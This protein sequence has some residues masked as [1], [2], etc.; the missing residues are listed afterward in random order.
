MEFLD[1]SKIGEFI[2]KIIK[3]RYLF[4]IFLVCILLAFIKYSLATKFLWLQTMIDKNK[5][6][7]FIIALISG[8]LW[9]IEIILLIWNS[10]CKQV[11]RQREKRQIKKRLK[12]LT[13]KEKQLLCYCI[14]NNILTISLPL[15]HSVAHS[16][17]DKGILIRAAGVGHMREWPYNI[18]DW[19]WEY[20]VNNSESIFGNLERQ[21]ISF[22]DISGFR[23]CT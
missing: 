1:F 23:D 12:Y 3:P 2:V 16:L 8:V 10:V 21:K 6:I 7:I 9:V 18:D 5:S 22:N 13:L 17:C 14:Q 19:L 15:G 4:G 20:L 11:S